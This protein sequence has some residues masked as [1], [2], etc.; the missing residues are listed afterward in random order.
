MTN[1]IKIAFKKV[2]LD[3]WRELMNEFI[4]YINI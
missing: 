1:I 4:K 3:E 2:I